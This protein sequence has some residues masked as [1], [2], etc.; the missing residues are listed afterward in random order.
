MMTNDKKG[1]VSIKCIPH[2]D[3][4]VNFDV[5]FVAYSTYLSSE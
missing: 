5:G 4:V 3:D 2:D 1:G